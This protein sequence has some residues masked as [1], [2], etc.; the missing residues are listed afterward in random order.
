MMMMKTGICS[1]TFRQFGIEKIV[2]LVK[3]AGLDAIEW[4]GDIHVKPGDLAAANTARK[5]TRDAGLE[6]SSYGSYYRVLE[7]E[8][9]GQ[10]FA[11]ILDA[12]LA[13]G[14]ETIRIWPGSRP[15]ETAGETYRKQFVEKLRRDLDLAAAAGVR[16]ALEFHMNSFTDSN[17]ATRKLLDEINHSNLYIY[18]Q[19]IYWLS[20][21]DYRLQGLE[22]FQSR[23][24]NLHVF[25]W[26]FHPTSGNWGENIERCPL[27]EAA[28]EWNRYLSALSPEINRYALMEFVRDD[29]PEQFLE[30]AQTL[31]QWIKEYNGTGIYEA[32][33]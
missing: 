16:L 33:L 28:A 19:P 23:I 32:D 15:S 1:I 18:W 20:D 7:D 6:V 2:G 9:K 3:R 22:M 31:R 5:M 12:A 14:T 29:S 25:N 26:K 17:A 4:G 27:K 30:D 10:D 11:P 24:L 8:N 21:F 13:L